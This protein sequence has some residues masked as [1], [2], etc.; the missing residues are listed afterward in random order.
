[1]QRADPSDVCFLGQKTGWDANENSVSFVF[2]CESKV[3]C[4]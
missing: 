2:L 3:G 1:M 4:Q